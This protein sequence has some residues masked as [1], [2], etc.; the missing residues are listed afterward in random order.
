MKIAQVTKQHIEA[1][2]RIDMLQRELAEQV[3]E[4]DDLH[5]FSIANDLSGG[6]ITLEEAIAR[7][8]GKDDRH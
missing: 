7:M 1:L 2:E 4:F 3:N 6:W 5:Q 8:D